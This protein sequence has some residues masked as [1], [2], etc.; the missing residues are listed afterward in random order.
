MIYIKDVQNLR[1]VFVF[2]TENQMRSRASSRHG[3]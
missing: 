2:T 1:I 3:V